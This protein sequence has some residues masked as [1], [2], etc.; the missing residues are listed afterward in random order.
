M[1]PYSVSGIVLY[2]MNERDY[3]C[4]YRYIIILVS[5][6]AVYFSKSLNE[7]SVRLGYGGLKLFIISLAV[8]ALS[9]GT[10]NVRYIRIDYVIYQISKL[11][12]G[13]Y[14]MHWGVGQIYNIYVDQYSGFVKCLII[15]LICLGLS[16]IASRVKWRALNL[17][18]M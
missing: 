5:V 17:I 4:K 3:L 14:C 13:V 16:Y 18:V 2:K 8:V 1:F 12:F 6:V 7:S 11:S 10:K 15:T 9:A